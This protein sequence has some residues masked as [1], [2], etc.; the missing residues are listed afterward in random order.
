MAAFG[1]LPRSGGLFD[2][3]PHEMRA[4]LTARSIEGLMRKR[5]NGKPFTLDE[6]RYWESLFDDDE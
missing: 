5:D 3:H 4:V 1:G 2:Q 6:T